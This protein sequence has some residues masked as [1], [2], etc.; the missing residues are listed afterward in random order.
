MLNGFSS[1]Y[2]V[3]ESGVPQGSVLGPLLFLVY[4]NDLEKD[5]K[6]RVK[7]FADD[8]MI[9]SVVRDTQLSAL[10]LNHD[11]KI[12]SQWAHQWKMVFNPDP[13]K[14][15]TEVLFSNKKSEVEHPELTFNN[16]PVIRVKEHKHLGLT[17]QS[18]LSF[19]KHLHDKMAKAKKNIGLIKHLNRFLPFETLNLMYKALVRSHLDYCDVIYHQ[20]PIYHP[21]PLG[22]TLHTLMEKVEKIQYQAALTVTGAW[23]GSNRVKLY[24]E[25]GWETLSDRRLSKRILHIHKIVDGKSPEYLRDL[26]PRTRRNMINLPF[27][28]QEVTCRTNRYA[29]SFL[30]DAICSWNNIITNFEGLPTYV[31]LKR[32]MTSLF[33]PQSRSIFGI[34]DPLNLRHLLQ[35]RVGLSPLRYH[36]K[37]HNFE[38]TPTD[39]CICK[40][41]VEDIQHYL[42]SCPFFTTHRISLTT[43]ISEILIKNNL[44]I[45]C[46]SIELYLYGHSSLSK[47]DNSEILKATLKYIK[48][49]NRF[50]K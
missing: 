48:S 49:T 4:I 15:A 47:S 12:I 29:N 3:I 5:I 11:L 34:H 37:R 30:P 26:M 21:P 9:F 19:E 18:N 46:D 20:P 1:E 7:F 8:T 40:T 38:D 23:Q 42:L 24:E 28:F 45:P 31:E 17:L 32:H 6:S 36:K 14:Q 16:I 44:D 2:N 33:R 43:R 13:T 10:E 50:A 35:L 39:S 22:T 41:G 25:L 27:A